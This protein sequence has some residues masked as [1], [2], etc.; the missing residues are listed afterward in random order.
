MQNTWSKCPHPIGACI[1]TFGHFSSVPYCTTPRLDPTA[2][3]KLALVLPAVFIC[4]I[5]FPVSNSRDAARIDRLKK[6]TSFTSWEWNLPFAALTCS[7]PFVYSK[8]MEH[9]GTKLHQLGLVK[10]N[11]AVS[12]L[13]WNKGWLCILWV[14]K[15]LQNLGEQIVE[16]DTVVVGCLLYINSSL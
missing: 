1:F 12:M 3:W 6:N 16:T 2:A 7:S 15:L 8:T 10:S 11:F 13:T 14:S 5:N 4:D 9:S